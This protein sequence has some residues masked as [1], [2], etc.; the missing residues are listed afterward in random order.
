MITDPMTVKIDDFTADAV[1]H[2]KNKSLVLDAGAGECRHKHL[3]SEENVT[4][5]A[6][7][8]LLGDSSWDYSNV[9]ISADLGKLPFRDS[10]VD[11][12]VNNQVLEHIEFPDLV[13]K[14]FS[15]ILKQGGVLYVT[16]PQGWYEHQEPHDYFRYTRYGLASL[17][18]RA[19]LHVEMIEPLGG[20]FQYVANRLSYLCK[21]FR[22]LPWKIRLVT[23]PFETIIVTV[24]GIIIPSLLNLMDGLDQEKKLTLGYRMIARKIC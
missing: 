12:I 20:A 7:D 1:H 9:D 21:L 19:G 24:F 22:Q 11:L 16:A 18:T 2:C 5:V 23:L 17:V 3:F 13:M 4:Y 8:F 10:S 6:L 15:R 14:E